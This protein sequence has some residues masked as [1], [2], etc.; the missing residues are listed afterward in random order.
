MEL[1]RAYCASSIPSFLACDEDSILGAL[2]AASEFSVDLPQRNAWQEEIRLRR[3]VLPAFAPGELFL[4]FG[5]R[6]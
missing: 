3:K 5:Q 2:T 6:V 1:K 4:E